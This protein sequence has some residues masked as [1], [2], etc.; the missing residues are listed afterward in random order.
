MKEKS[1][2]TLTPGVEGERQDASFFGTPEII[3]LLFSHLSKQKRVSTTEM[4]RRHNIQQ[5]NIQQND[6]QYYRKSLVFMYCSALSI[7]LWSVLPGNPY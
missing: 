3:F 7:A 4:K 5:K 6:A 1:F 2:I